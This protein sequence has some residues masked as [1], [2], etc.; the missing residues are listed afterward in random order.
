MKCFYCCVCDELFFVMLAGCSGYKG[1]INK[2][3]DPYQAV[4][5]HEGERNVDIDG[6]VGTLHRA[7]ERVVT[8]EHVVKQS[9]LIRYVTAIAHRLT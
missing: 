7:D 9:L 5:L 1:L 8:M 4:Y 6:L 3:C 2:E